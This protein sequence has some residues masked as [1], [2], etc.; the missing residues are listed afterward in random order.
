MRIR[1][2]ADTDVFGASPGPAESRGFGRVDGGWPS[3]LRQR[4]RILAATGVFFAFAAYYG[5]CLYPGVGGTI[6]GGDSAKVQVLA[7]AQIMLH[8]PGYPL[9]LLLA[10]AVRALDLSAPGWWQIAF[11]LSAVPGALAVSL[12]FLIGERAARSFLFGVAG[13]L[14]V[15]GAHLMAVQAT[16]AEVYALNIVLVLAVIYLLLLFVDTERLPFF[17]AASAVYAIS[18]GNHLMMAMLIPLFA[19][20][21]FRYR[22]LILR[23]GP[24][25]IILAF[26]LLGASQYLYLAHV[27]YHPATAYSEYMPLPP[28]PP[29][30]VRYVLGI[31]FSDLYGSGLDSW[32]AVAALAE[33]FQKAHPWLAIPLVAG[34]LAAFLVHSPG[35]SHEWR[36]AA[37]LHV[38]ALSFL[39]FVLWYG[40]FDIEAFHLPVLALALLA[41]T[42][43]LGL[44]ARHRFPGLSGFAFL[45]IAVGAFRLLQTGMELATRQPH[46]AGIVP[47]IRQALA[48][49]PQSGEPPVLALGYDV[50]MAA[51]YHFFAGDL[52]RGP[53]YRL[54]WRLPDDL[55]RRRTIAGAAIPRNAL[56]FV[57]EVQRQRPDLTCRVRLLNEDEAR[58]L[59]A[60][61]FR[62][63][64]GS[65]QA[66]RQAEP[67]DGHP[68]RFPKL[69]PAGG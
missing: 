42:A 31:Y 63:V 41:A 69:V 49:L 61:G 33:T 5:L 54:S 30:L 66:R 13:A 20:L 11:A 37:L 39:P 19:V 62:C 68:V 18:F 35:A 64:E 44:A 50:R 29:E 6:N 22:R 32:R 38:A 36:G 51:M 2:E 43:S 10:S 26:V 1:L 4:R 40:A 24:V 9:Y 56:Y 48:R 67:A 46:I 15:G 60:Y 65:T 58:Q 16:E 53:E 28:S 12:A 3:W 57:R 25:A 21:A 55:V 52:P 59:P 47:Q 34:G 17:L 27:A 8:G 45:L 7:H 23:P 14:L